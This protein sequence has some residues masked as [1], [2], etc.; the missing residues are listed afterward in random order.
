M[1]LWYQ[2]GYAMLPPLAVML[3][4]VGA[5]SVLGKTV[6]RAQMQWMGATDARIKL[7]VG[8]FGDWDVGG[9]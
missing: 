5:T 6:D 4:F 3:L 1:I 9:R 8:F 2:A 7:M